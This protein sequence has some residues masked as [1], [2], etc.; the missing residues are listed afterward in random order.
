[1]TRCSLAW[2]TSVRTGGATQASGSH[3]GCQASRACTPPSRSPF[4]IADQGGPPHLRTIQ[5]ILDWKQFGIQLAKHAKPHINATTP[6]NFF[7]KLD[8]FSS[9]PVLSWSCR[10]LRL[11]LHPT[12]HI[13][14]VC[15]LLTSPYRHP[16]QNLVIWWL[17]PDMVAQNQNGRAH[18]HHGYLEN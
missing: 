16:P 5:V 15:V 13:Q 7:H 3:S 14:I 17:Y 1:V 10:Y 8:Q 18:Q 4:T 11:N 12:A 6:F 9:T 2:R